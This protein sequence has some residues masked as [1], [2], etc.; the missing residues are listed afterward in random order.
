M[1]K[2]DLGSF[3]ANNRE[4]RLFY[5]LG[6]GKY[7]NVI[8][9]GNSTY[10]NFLRFHESEEEVVYLFVAKTKDFRIPRDEYGYVRGD[11]LGVLGLYFLKSGNDLRK[12]LEMIFKPRGWV[13]TNLNYES[14]EELKKEL[15]KRLVVRRLTK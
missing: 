13:I 3:K 11:T 15:F 10:G 4:Y 8:Y 6:Y 5:R 2:T 7:K 9:I 12:I 14:R 1:A